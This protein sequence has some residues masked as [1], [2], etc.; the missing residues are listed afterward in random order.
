[1]AVS[2]CHTL[3]DVAPWVSFSDCWLP[4]EWD[5][6]SLSENKQNPQT[7]RSGDLFV[8]EPRGLHR[9]GSTGNVVNN[10]FC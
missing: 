1:M 6:H 9:E 10:V 8:P 5:A 3:I 7:R 4:E 2:R